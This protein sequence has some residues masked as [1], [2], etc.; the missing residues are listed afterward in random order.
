METMCFPWRPI[1]SPWVRYL[2]NSFLITPWTIWRKRF[3][4]RSI[5]RSIIV[6]GR[7]P[8]RSAYGISPPQT[9]F[10]PFKVKGAVEATADGRIRVHAKSVRGFGLP[11]KPLMKLFGIEMDDLLKVEPGHGV[12]V[13]D[14]DLILDPQLM[15]PPPH[16][17]GKVTAVEVVG[18]TLV[19]TFGT[20]TP[21]RLSPPAVSP[22]HIYW[23]GGNLKFG[24]LT[25]S[26]TDLELVDM[27]PKDPFDFSVHRWND[28]LVAGYS[29]NTVA[30]AGSRPTCP[31]SPTSAAAPTS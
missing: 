30:D 17:R 26:N 25:M 2:R 20:G 27:D 28:Q 22:N 24:K 11:V 18:D 14:N 13:D 31:T 1:S 3:T 5:L 15:L 23:R 6:I 4:S 29:K 8:V 16:I 10:G 19:Q 12:A 9:R 21:H 7:G